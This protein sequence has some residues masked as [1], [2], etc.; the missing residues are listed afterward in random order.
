MDEY[1]QTLEIF[2]DE[3]MKF[4]KQKDKYIKCRGC[5]NKKIFTE[6][7]EKLEMTCGSTSGECGPQII[8]ELPKYIH[9]KNRIKELKESI[10]AKYNWEELKKFLDVKKELSETLENQETINEEIKR[11]EKLYYQENIEIKK[12]EIQVFYEKTVR[13][14]KRCKEIEKE[15]N[16]LDTNNSRKIELRKEY[17][18]NVQEMNEDY[19]QTK[20]L[21]EDIN[22]YSIDEEPKIKIKSENYLYEK[23]NVKNPDKKKKK[24][25]NRSN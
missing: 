9:Y 10:D 11:I 3:K 1:L 25:I 16:S 13:K 15:L 5:E 6:T 20:E 24:E 21:I 19:I 14:T 4:L 2:H 23:K 12:K 7:D 17:V 8:I 18:N 22:P